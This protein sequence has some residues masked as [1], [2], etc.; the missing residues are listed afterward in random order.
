MV[1]LLKSLGHHIILYSSEAEDN[2]I[3]EYVDEL[4]QVITVE[5]VETLLNA[6][7]NE[8][9]GLPDPTPRW[10][11]YQEVWN[12]IW[13]LANARMIKQIT[14]R[15]QPHD[16]ILSIGGG[17]QKPVADWN[18]DLMFVEWSIGYHG[19]FSQYRVFE[20][21]AWKHFTYGKQ[22]LDDGRF[23][24]AVIPIPYDIDEF[25]FRARKEPFALFLG[26][27]VPRKGIAIACQA[28]AAAGLPLKI[29]GHGDP[30]LITHGAEYLG[31]LEMDERNEWVSRA[32]CVLTPTQYLEPFC[33]SVIE[34]FLLGTP[35][36]TTNWGG[37]TETVEAGMGFRCN[38]LGEFAQA[39][40]NC[41][42]LDPNYI[43]R[44]AVE[45]YSY[46][47]VK[48]QYAA[49]FERLQLLQTPEGWNSLQ[50]IQAEEQNEM[51]QV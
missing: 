4:V 41:R 44:R 34:S 28:A 22:G 42:H 18:P 45:K 29:I 38:Y 24:D 16:F 36:V 17:S 20:S 31:A 30:S 43:R 37:F 32:Q 3:L 19:S 6:T 15:K 12:P 11:A 46:H 33:Q 23:F 8:K 21:E 47:N 9:T 39:I 13:Q 14:I 2:D 51:E 26:R 49:Y 7:T 50:L 25:P 10:Y 5:E 35:V 48:H 40:H 1:K 27:L